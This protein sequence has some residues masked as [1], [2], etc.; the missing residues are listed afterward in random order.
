MWQLAFAAISAGGQLMAGKASRD[1]ARLTAYNIETEKI[2]NSAMATQQANARREEYD[3]ATSANLAQFAAQGRDI[4]S[5]RSVQAFLERQKEIVGKDIGRI[6]TQ[7]QMENLKLG[8]EAAQ[9][10]LRGSTAYTSS[11]FSAIGTIGEGIQRYQ[12][13]RT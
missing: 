4:G 7:V 13:T 1:A 9:E 6:G 8:S 12:Q 2:A 10:R 11:V 5:D 3:L